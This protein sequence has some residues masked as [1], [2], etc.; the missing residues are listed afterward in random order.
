MRRDQQREQQRRAPHAQEQAERPA[1]DHEPRQLRDREVG[2]RRPPARSRAARAAP[3]RSSTPAA[4]RTRRGARGSCRS[5]TRP[6]SRAARPSGRTRR[7]SGTAARCIS[8]PL[9]A[10][11]AP[12]PS[13][14]A[15]AREAVDRA[16]VRE[17]AVVAAARGRRQHDRGLAHAEQQRRRAGRPSRPITAP[18]VTRGHCFAGRGFDRRR[19]QL[20]ALGIIDR[21]RRLVAN[22][23]REKTSPP[24][25]E[26]I[27]STA[28]P[29]VGIS[30]ADARRDADA[31]VQRDR[32]R[33][34]H[35]DAVDRD[36]HQRDE[37]LHRR[38]EEHRADATARRRA[39]APSRPRSGC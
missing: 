23:A 26:T 6:R 31:R 27:I 38:D 17:H 15:A 37:R 18:R 35:A 34:A 32:G 11:S 28:K 22:A 12:S 20:L 14:A 29:R 21:D 13:P 4:R 33:L 24:N 8:R 3:G 7:G 25:A 16:A 36:R 9:H 2:D 39:R 1:R 10:S 5:R 19:R 30:N